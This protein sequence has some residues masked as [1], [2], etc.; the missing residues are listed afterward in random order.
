LAVDFFFMLSGFVVAYAYEAKMNNGMTMGEFYLR[1]VIRLY[2]LIIAGAFGGM[3]WF[4]SCDL[5]FR[6]DPLA[7]NAVLFAALGLP[8]R[9]AQ[10]S[11]SLFPIN[12]PQWSLFYELLAYICFGALITRA[13]TLRLIVFAAVMCVL[14]VATHLIYPR[15]VPFALKAFGPLALFSIGVLL[16]RGHERGVLPNYNIPFIILA[17]ILFAPCAT[18]LS[19]GFGIGLFYRIILCPSLIICGVAR[20]RGPA[21]QIEQFLGEIS[22]PLYI[23]HWP[24][25]LATQYMFM[26]SIGSAGTVVI[27]CST[28]VAIAW[29][30]LIIFDRPVRKWLS[31]KLLP[32]CR[33]PDDCSVF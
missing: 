32:R 19:S 3:L 17:F 6:S 11:F 16:W 28:A 8:L 27:G 2:P 12:P 25:L 31:E 24:V 21:G 23:L 14:T 1:R 22:Y 26:K 10:F 30:A 15:G 7:F 20:C 29:V 9:G 18:P 4:A 13:T 33:I 5:N